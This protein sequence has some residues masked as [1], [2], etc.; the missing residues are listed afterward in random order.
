MDDR[1]FRNALLG[2]SCTILPVL[3]YYRVRSQS[4]G[5]S[6]D[7]RQEGIFI[8]ATLRPAAL[9]AYGGIIAFLI[10]PGYMT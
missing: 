10:D 8:L 3:L 9:L 6:L 7:R 4:T 1:V 2:I 5:E